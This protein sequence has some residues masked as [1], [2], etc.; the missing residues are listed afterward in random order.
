MRFADIFAKAQGHTD[1]HQKQGNCTKRGELEEKKGEMQQCSKCPG[2]PQP[3]RC[4]Q[5]FFFCFGGRPANQ[6]ITFLP[7]NQIGLISVWRCEGANYY[8]A[9][10]DA[11]V[12]WQNKYHLMVPC[13]LAALQPCS[14]SA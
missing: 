1:N 8:S 13:S 9:G 5:F 2:Q 14:L 11:G 7:I 3:K 4:L 6:P 12:N 10:M